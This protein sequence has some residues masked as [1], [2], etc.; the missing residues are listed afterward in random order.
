MVGIA[1]VWLNGNINY[2]NYTPDSPYSDMSIFVELSP[3]LA[4]N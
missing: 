3:I 1:Q 4:N 2:I